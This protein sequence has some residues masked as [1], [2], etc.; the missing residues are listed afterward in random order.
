MEPRP[1]LRSVNPLTDLWIL[2]SLPGIHN[3][4]EGTYLSHVDT[5]EI[6]SSFPCILHAASLMGENTQSERTMLFDAPRPIVWSRRK[7]KIFRMP[8]LFP[9]FPPLSWLKVTLPSKWILK[10]LFVSRG[11]SRP[12]STS[13][14]QLGGLHFSCISASLVTEPMSSQIPAILLGPRE[15]NIDVW[16]QRLSWCAFHQEMDGFKYF[17]FSQR[18]FSLR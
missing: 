9:S 3:Q 1:P 17:V 5:R 13:E 8:E 16:K 2:Q 6:D 15:Q 18:S 12:P 7:V 10:C 4:T 11:N 14:R